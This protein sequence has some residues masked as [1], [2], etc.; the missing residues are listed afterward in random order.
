KGFQSLSCTRKARHC[1]LY[2]SLVILKKGEQ[3][4]DDKIILFPKMRVKL[5]QEVE[6]EIQQENYTSAIEKLEV[7]RNHGQ[8]SYSIHIQSLICYIRLKRFTEAELLCEELLDKHDEHYMDYLDYYI[9]ILFEAKKYQA[10]IERIEEETESGELPEELQYK[11]QEMKILA[12]Q[13]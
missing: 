12:E 7:L 11:F 3:I 10:V 2:M 8:K 4:L 5:E 13:M 1:I 6:R 9:I